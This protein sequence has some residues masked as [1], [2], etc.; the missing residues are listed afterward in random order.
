MGGHLSAVLHAITIAYDRRCI[1]AYVSVQIDRLDAELTTSGRSMRLA[2]RRCP[3]VAP[4]ER[5]A[6]H[7]VLDAKVSN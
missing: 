1:D 5:A 4:L 6:G 2:Q 3:A 7:F